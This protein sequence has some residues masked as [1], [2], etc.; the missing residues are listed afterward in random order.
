MELLP[1]GSVVLLKNGVKTLMIYGRKQLD[2]ETGKTFDYLGCLYPEG[3][4]SEDMNF[5]FNGENIE[6]VLFKGY[7]NEEELS[8]RKLLDLTDEDYEKFEDFKK[9]YAKEKE[10]GE[11]EEISEEDEEEILRDMPTESE[12]EKDIDAL[13]E[14]SSEI[15]KIIDNEAKPAEE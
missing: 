13:D 14:F 10:N 7:E 15:F 12:I 2:V 8:V 11:T 4:I 6:K 5:L 9:S 1:I 3:N